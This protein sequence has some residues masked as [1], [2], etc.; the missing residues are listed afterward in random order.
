[1]EERLSPASG[2]RRGPFGPIVPVEVLA[3]SSSP[4]GDGR[5]AASETEPGPAEGAPDA[6]VE[7]P[8]GLTEPM[9]VAPAPVTRKDEGAVTVPPAPRGADRPEERGD[10]EAER[11]V[12]PAANAP[13][14]QEPTRT[15]TAADVPPGPAEPAPIRTVRQF[16][17]AWEKL[18]PSG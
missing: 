10:A 8:S 4:A 16:L 17:D 18:G 13:P 12:E 9:T 6:R 14:P 15:P 7:E 2:A 1:P 3:L 5:R 11:P